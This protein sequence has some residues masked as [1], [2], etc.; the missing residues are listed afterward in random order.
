MTPIRRF[1]LILVLALICTVS[2]PGFA[3]IGIITSVAG[4]GPNDI[5]ASQ[6]NVCS[7]TAVILDSDGNL[8]VTS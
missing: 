2:L 6:A 4:G 5:P 7:P 3:Q 1:L 8:Y